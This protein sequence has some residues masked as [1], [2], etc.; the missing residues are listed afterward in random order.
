MRIA[1][2]KPDIGVYE[3]RYVTDTLARNWLTSAGDYHEKFERYLT[4]F[5]GRPTIATNCGTGAVTIAMLAA[6][7]RAGDDVVMPTLTFGSPAS[8]VKMMG[9]N[10]IL[11][12]VD[13]T[14]CLQPES[15]TT[16]QTKV[17][18]A[19]N[20]YG[21]QC[22]IK[23]PHTVIEDACES[24]GVIRPRA[25]Y[26]CYSFFAN[27][28]ITTGEGGALCAKRM[29]FCKAMRDGGFDNDY[30]MIYP[31]LNF[32]MTA[33]QAA[34]GCAQMERVDKLLA[35]RKRNVRTY[36]ENLKGFGEWLFVA[37]VK[38]PQRTQHE[39]K[40]MG[41][42]TRRVFTPLHMSPAFGTDGKF[43]V[44]E[45]IFKHGLCLPTGHL[46]KKEVEYV[47]DAI[48][49]IERG[50]PLVKPP[51]PAQADIQAGAV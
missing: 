17:V 34:L 19:V 14:A 41:I 29:T 22:D 36:H 20:L 18:L 15:L 12:D 48:K 51:R 46:E 13:E 23:Y 40:G 33:L 7:L 43:P 2:A 50:N 47:C 25:D 16:D 35:R 8:V 32:C 3:H 38:S 5:L 21:M 45:D 10:L 49:R 9:A 1:L 30:N 11:R 42:E 39:L 37:R 4:N 6:G 27:K 28:F 24:F 44:A 26:V 31:G